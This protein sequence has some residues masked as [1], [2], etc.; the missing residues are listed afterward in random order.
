MIDVFTSLPLT[1][2]KPVTS[3]SLD[4]GAFFV[5]SE[6]FILKEIMA[7]LGYV[8]NLD[9]TP[10]PCDHFD[11]IG[12][13]GAGGILAL[14]LG[15]L[16][17]SVDAAIEHFIHLCHSLYQSTL[18]KAKR[19][20]RLVEYF[21]GLCGDNTML[22]SKPSC[23]THV[24]LPLYFVCAMPAAA[25]NGPKPGLFR[26]YIPRKFASF[27]CKIWEAARATTGHPSLFEI[28]SIGHIWCT[29]DYVDPGAFGFSN[30]ID[31]V[32]QETK[33]LFPS[34]HES[35]FLSLGAGHPGVFSFSACRDEMASVLKT[36]SEDC[37]RA[38]Y[39][40]AEQDY[41]G[42]FRFDV[43]HGLQASAAHELIKPGVIAARTKN[44]LHCIDVDQR[45]DEVVHF[46]ER[47]HHQCAFFSIASTPVD[48]RIAILLHQIKSVNVVDFQM[49]RE[50]VARPNYSYFTG[51]VYAEK[52]VLIQVFHGLTPFEDRDRT[53]E[54]HMVVR[55]PNLLAVF[56][57]SDYVSCIFFAN[58]NLTPA[59]ERLARALEL[60]D[61]PDLAQQGISLI[62][63]LASGLDF[64]NNQAIRYI[65]GTLPLQDFVVFA[66]EDGQ[67]L[68]A[69]TPS[70]VGLDGNVQPATI[71]VDLLQEICSKTVIDAS[72]DAHA[73]RIKSNHASLI[74]EPL[75]SDAIPGFI[76]EESS[77]FPGDTLLESSRPPFSSQV[78]SPTHTSQP[79]L[80]SQ[81]RLFSWQ[82]THPEAAPSLPDIISRFRQ[83]SVMNRNVRVI[84]PVTEGILDI[85][86]PHEEIRL[87][88]WLDS[89][90]IFFH[91]GG[92]SECNETEP[93][94]KESQDFSNWWA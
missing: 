43:P 68:V 52:R 37:G 66:K 77:S 47:R 9:S 18:D 27:N 30:P 67:Y 40:M 48:S 22:E 10:F 94:G 64:L 49:D 32:L 44:Y 83:L 93:E 50:L 53:L 15:R 74:H 65:R 2:M 7:R 56:Q 11:V 79:I 87:T 24:L 60:T 16:R 76:A 20:E 73:G 36:L 45:V 26:N 91:P 63:G 5:L 90:S 55:H 61:A 86:V 84:P 62:G 88:L 42:Y 14:L 1:T 51:R 71:G 39:R 12:G 41:A 75:S 38:A 80:G 92:N 8:L 19:S 35:L 59:D 78:P 6:L 34:F 29:E 3:L 89:S 70:S 46:L 31:F 17:M 23:N 82:S 4:G 21:E 69:F 57:K 81:H 33:S 72:R 13:S 54:A 85:P 58:E 25:I 28:I